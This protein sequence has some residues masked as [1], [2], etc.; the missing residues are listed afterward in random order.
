MSVYRQN[1]R[2][3]SRVLE[4]SLFVITPDDNTLHT[5]NATATAI[6]ERAVNGCTVADAVEA[7]VSQY[8]VDAER[9]LADVAS[10]CDELVRRRILVCEE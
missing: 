3:A 1:P 10:C 5:L 9:A 8:D 2:T 6:W 4:G 7:V